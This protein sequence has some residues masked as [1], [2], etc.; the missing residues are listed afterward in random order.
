MNP[1]VPI[2]AGLAAL[3]LYEASKKKLPVPPPV[4]GP[5]QGQPA[6]P[7]Q[8]WEV[9]PY[10][11]EL[12]A[13]LNTTNTGTWVKMTVTTQTDP[14][15]TRQAADASSAVLSTIPKGA[16]VMANQSSATNGY[17]LVFGRNGD[18]NTGPAGWA[19]LTYLAAS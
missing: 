7:S 2:L 13:Y 16:D 3:G 17:A 4:V 1:V 10:T 8:A 9:V 11:P 6:I 12:L 5:G 15:V 18:G 14:L 19:S